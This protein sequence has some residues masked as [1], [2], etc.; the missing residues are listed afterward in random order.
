MLSKQKKGPIINM[1]KSHLRNINVA[2]LIFFFCVVFSIIITYFTT[3]IC[4]DSDASSELVLAEHLSK[5]GQILSTDWFYSTELRVINTQLIYAPLFWIFDDWHMVR[6]FGALILQ[7]LLIASFYF[8]TKLLGLE[9]NV[10][11][12][13]SSLFLLP[14]SV[15]YGRILLYNCYYIP[16]IVFSLIIV[17][18]IFTKKTGRNRTSK[19]IG[20]LALLIV[21]FL[22]G[23]GGIRQL[24]MTHIPTVLAVFIYYFIDD[25]INKSDDR[26][27]EIKRCTYIVRAVCA[28]IFSYIGFSINKGYFAQNYSFTDYSENTIKFLKDSLD[29]V[30]YGYFHHF[31]F[32]DEIKLLSVTGVLS[33]LGIVLGIYCIV[34]SVCRIISHKKE[35]DAQKNLP[36]VFFISYTVVMLFVFLIVGNGYYFVLY[37]TP[38]VI[39]MIPV[40]VSELHR[41]PKQLS[42]LN[43]KKI[44]PF[45]MVAIIFANGFVNSAFLISGEVFEQKYEGLGYKTFNARSYITPAVSFLQENG[46]DLGYAEFWSSN[47]CTEIS[48]GKIKMINVNM[49]F[50][51]GTF[52]YY[53]WLT[54]K[55]NRS[56]EDKKKFLLL[57]AEEYQ[58][59]AKTEELQKCEIV[60]KD[61]YYTIFDLAE[62]NIVK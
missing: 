45:A 3:R 4:I 59:M 22:G 12:L 42:C 21:S 47:I 49:N 31:G 1:K 11:Y 55:S 37:L 8:Y 24:M 51:D 56:L 34:V 5:T 23:L 36:F 14:V 60:Y 61:D 46:Y 62:H 58:K 41:V 25:Y 20:F 43:L 33:A 38:I 57:S 15:C 17:G 30:L 13:C 6:F 10:F 35:A 16:H 52:Y 53:D 2:K 28:T 9:K 48:N 7:G 40:F 39:W 18:L 26:V 32:R 44:L 54:L 27:F 50:N 29:Q 19:Y